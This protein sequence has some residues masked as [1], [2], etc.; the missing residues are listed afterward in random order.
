MADKS[1]TSLR[2]PRNIALQK[3]TVPAGFT[4]GGELDQSMRPVINKDDAAVT[5]GASPPPSQPSPF[6]IKGGGG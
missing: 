1:P 6:Q 3:G 2:T 5:P 4:G